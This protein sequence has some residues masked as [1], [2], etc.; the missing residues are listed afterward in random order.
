[1]HWVKYHEHAA[2]LPENYV[3]LGDAW[4]RLNPV[5]GQGMAKAVVEATTLDGVLRGA[6]GPAVGRAFFAR[7]AARTGGVW[8]QTKIGDYAHASCAPAAGETRALGARRRA[9]NARV[10]KRGLRGDLDVQRRMLGVRGWVLPATDMM[11][12]SV[13]GKLALDWVRGG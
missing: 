9:F 3:A 7:A 11:A 4:M 6:A 8:T 10:G 2:T 13:L 5:F 1:M 12:P